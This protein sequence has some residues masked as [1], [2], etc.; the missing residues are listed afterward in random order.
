MDKIDNLLVCLNEECAEVQ[1]AVSKA[2]RFGLDNFYLDENKTNA[3]D[4]I[5]ECN[6]IIAVIEMLQE[7]NIVKIDRELVERKK[8]KV[9]SFIEVSKR[10]GKIT[11]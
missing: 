4:I 3:D 11:E 6:D 7:Y 9:E 1:Q 2:L 10:C 5:A 8:R